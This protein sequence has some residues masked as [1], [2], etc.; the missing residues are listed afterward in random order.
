MRNNTTI[1]YFSWSNFR[2]Y[3]RVHEL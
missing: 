3:T 1:A 2:S